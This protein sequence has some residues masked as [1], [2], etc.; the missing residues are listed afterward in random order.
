MEKIVRPIKTLIR[1]ISL[2]KNIVCSKIR[3]LFH[4]SIARKSLYSYNKKFSA[5]EKIVFYTCKN[6]IFLRVK[7]SFYNIASFIYFVCS[8]N[9]GFF[10]NVSEINRILHGCLEI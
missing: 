4:G 5:T 6:T 8:K 7:I 2:V 1:Q 3:I 10:V 9:L